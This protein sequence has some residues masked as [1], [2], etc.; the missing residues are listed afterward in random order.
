MSTPD[1]TH[2]RLMTF[3]LAKVSKALDSVSKIVSNGSRVVFELAVR[4]LKNLWSGDKL[5]L[6]ENNGVY[7]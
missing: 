1:R 4:T 2:T 7:V 5:W 6:R 3:Q